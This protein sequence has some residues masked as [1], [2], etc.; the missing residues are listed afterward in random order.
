[1]RLL[2][3]LIRRDGYWEGMASGAAVLTSSY[4]SADREAV[5]PQ[6]TAWAQ[7]ANASSAVVFAASLTRMAL[8]CEARFQYQAKD[9]KHLFGNTTLA[10]L[11]VPF[12]PDT[13]TGDLLARMEPVS[14]T[15]L[16]LP[17]ILLV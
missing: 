8:F 12:G 15:H 17:T 11:E 14:Y 16:T 1:M 5:L 3:Q 7:N 4:S 13:T 6:L 9:D 10:K 2:D